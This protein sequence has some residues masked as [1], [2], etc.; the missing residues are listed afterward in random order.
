[1]IMPGKIVSRLDK[2]LTDAIDGSFIESDYDET[3]LSKLEAKW[4]NF[5]ET[6]VLSKENLEK[7]KENIKIREK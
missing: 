4:K 2:M 1:M 6:S 3:E 5:L 7:E